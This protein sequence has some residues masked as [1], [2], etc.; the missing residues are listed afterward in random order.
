MQ[1]STSECQRIH[2]NPIAEYLPG[3]ARGVM[4]YTDAEDAEVMGC[5]QRDVVDL[6]PNGLVLLKVMSR[7]KFHTR[8]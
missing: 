7:G 3:T 1:Q 4:F 5:N 6:Q 8:L 2:N